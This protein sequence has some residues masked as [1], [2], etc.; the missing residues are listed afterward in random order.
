M[1][2][3][4]LRE[5]L[6]NLPGSPGVYLMRDAQGEVIYVGKA[7]RLRQRVRSYFQKYHQQND[8]KVLSLSQLVADL[9]VIV[10]R[11][12]VEALV[13]EDQLIKSHRPRFNI[14]LK[15][16]KRFPYI[17]ITVEDPFPR[18]L[19]SRQ[20]EGDGARYFGPYTNAQLMRQ[21]LNALRRLFPVR[22]CA[23]DIGTRPTRLRPCLDFF[24]HQCTA[25]C[26]QRVPGADY[27]RAVQ[28]LCAFLEGRSQGLFKAV[29][30]QMQDASASLNFERAAQLRDTLAALKA[31]SGQHKAVSAGSLTA[32]DVVGVA[33]GQASCA[34][35]VFFVRDGVIKGR[36][37]F[38]L[39]VPG[40]S[41]LDEVLQAFLTQF[42]SEAVVIPREILLPMALAQG[43]WI[44]RWLS[45]RLS[46][47]VKL[48]VPQRGSKHNLVGLAT[49]NAELALFE[50]H[51]LAKRRSRREAALL[52]LQQDLN[53]PRLP[54][55][56]ECYDISNIQGQ[57]AVGAMTVFEGGMPKKADYR[58][59]RI[60]SVVGADDFA[61]MGEMLERRLRHGLS[62]QDALQAQ[63]SSS[64]AT[65]KFAKLPDLIVLDGGKGQLGA[66]LHVL[67]KL[68]LDDL[69]I[70][71]LAKRQEEVFV[72]R[73]AQAV[74]LPR[75]SEALYLLQHIRD[76][77]HRFG[78]AYHRS[79]RQRRTVHS[80]LDDIPGVGPKRRAKL[81]QHFGSITRIKLATV[82]ELQ[83]V[84]G[85]SETVAKQIHAALHDATSP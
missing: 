75:D 82:Q 67:K 44:E 39:E 59:F 25:P 14:R 33:M 42:Y 85:I 6:G 64:E 16:D 70:I 3:D 58:R 17:K 24:I 81:I 9:E 77:A 23:D 61:M 54:E 46:Q 55:R 26:V 50:Q 21:T 8:P 19:I 41:S 60:R 20:L 15:D 48:L 1:P 2:S 57:D 62:E 35:Q 53:L 31:L 73:R 63:P 66:G 29:E 7:L 27:A 79:L 51:H 18:L 69:P 13:L 22:T 78:L 80:A 32:R 37:H 45:E 68:R 65:V 4:A 72:P 47:P 11:S 10:T 83:T 71:A 84:P 36:E 43:A 56:I 30:A 52:Q 5:K 28:Q 40:R 74:W 38:F 76:E 12:E 49:R 34:I